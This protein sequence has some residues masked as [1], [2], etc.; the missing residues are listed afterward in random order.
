ME[1]V[2]KGKINEPLT[3]EE[4][5]FL[6]DVLSQCGICGINDIDIKEKE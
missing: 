1:I 5:E 2:I 4:N 3:E 6:L